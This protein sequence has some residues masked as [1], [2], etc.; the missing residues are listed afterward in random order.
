[1][2]CGR[3]LFRSWAGHSSAKIP[4]KSWDFLGILKV[5]FS[6][7]SWLHIVG[8]R[9]ASEPIPEA[10]LL[11]TPVGWRQTPKEHSLLPKLQF[12]ITQVRG[13][14]GSNI[15]ASIRWVRI[16]SQ[17]PLAQRDSPLGWWVGWT[18]EQSNHW[19]YSLVSWCRDGAQPSWVIRWLRWET[20]IPIS[21][22]KY[23]FNLLFILR[24]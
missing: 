3:F 8:Y 15:T 24:S 2:P 5:K 1:M 17:L 21:R 6:A 4:N 13:P 18:A 22:R 12:P 16:L 20:F 10:Q 19:Q 11:Y 7:S 9:L 23:T 14:Q